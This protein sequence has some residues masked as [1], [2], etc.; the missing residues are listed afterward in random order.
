MADFHQMFDALVGYLVGMT[1]VEAI[2][3]PTLVRYAKKTLKSIDESS[4][5]AS[6]V[7]PDW[8]FAGLAEEAESEPDSS[9]DAK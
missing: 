9:V 6:V 2:V 7:I 3:K 8:L 5:T 1:L 4:K